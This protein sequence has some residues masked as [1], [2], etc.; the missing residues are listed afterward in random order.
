MRAM[1]KTHQ[2]HKAICK[3][4][5]TFQ[6]TKTASLDTFGDTRPPTYYSEN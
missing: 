6:Q 1:A 3:F 4:I 5:M 2:T